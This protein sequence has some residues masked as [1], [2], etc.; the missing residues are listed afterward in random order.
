MAPARVLVLFPNAW[1]RVQFGKAKYEKTHAFT[2]EGDD[3]F[4]F[5]GTLKLITFDAVEWVADIA[6]KYR[7]KIDGVLSTDEYIGA[8]IAAAVARELGLPANDPGKIIEA[9]HK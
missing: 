8:I 6:R 7:G 4:K 9:Q 2:F 1:D 5:P 3:F